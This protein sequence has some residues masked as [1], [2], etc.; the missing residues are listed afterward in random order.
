MAKR[1]VIP[2]SKIYT[3][4][5]PEHKFHPIRRWRFDWAW[6][7]LKLAVEIE[8]GVWIGG[9]HTSGSGFEKD[10]EKYN[11]AVLLGWRILR[12][13]PKQMQ[14][15]EAHAMIDRALGLSP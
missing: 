11:E 8:G 12:F 7:H 10:M 2:L 1:A 5:E 13:T 15:G 4:C 9:R 6:P 3:G 14:S